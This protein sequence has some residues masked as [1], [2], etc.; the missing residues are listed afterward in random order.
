MSK[1][2]ENQKK[3]KNKNLTNGGWRNYWWRWWREEKKKRSLNIGPFTFMFWII[4]ARTTTAFAPILIAPSSS[5]SIVRT[6]YLRSV[7]S[8]ACFDP[9]SNSN[10]NLLTQAYSVYNQRDKRKEKK[11][12]PCPL[13]FYSST[14]TRGPLLKFR[15]P[16]RFNFK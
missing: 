12:P 10:N 2:K 7:A 13:Y 6:L 1:K 4:L 8:I 9:I 14:T 5:S 15:F 16:I 3:N 11:K